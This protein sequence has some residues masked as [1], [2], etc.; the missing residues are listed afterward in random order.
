LPSLFIDLSRTKTSGAESGEVVYLT[1][2]LVE[3]LNDW[4][5]AASIDKGRVFRA[6]DRWGNVSRLPLDQK[7]INDILKHRAELAGLNPGEFSA[8]GLRSS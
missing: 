6:T 1:G 4:L 3:S 5:D 2:R 7:A 8:H